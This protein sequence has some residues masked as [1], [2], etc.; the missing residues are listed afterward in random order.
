MADRRDWGGDGDEL[1][2]STHQL[3]ERLWESI[4]EIRTRLDKQPPVQP[5]VAAPPVEEEVVLVPLAPPPPPPGV[6]VLPVAPVPPV[7]PI[8]SAMQIQQAKIEQFRTLQQGNLSVLELSRTVEEAA[9]RAAI[10]ERT[11]HASR[12]EEAAGNKVFNRAKVLDQCWR[13]HSKVQPGCKAGGLENLSSTDLWCIRKNVT[14]TS[15]VILHERDHLLRRNSITAFHGRGCMRA[16]W[17]MQERRSLIATMGAGCTVQLKGELCG[18][19]AGDSGLLVHFS[20]CFQREEVLQSVENAKAVSCQAWAC[21][22]VVYMS[23]IGWSPQFLDLVEVERQ[24]DLS[25]VAA[26]LR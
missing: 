25:S 13:S 16:A 23:S 21:S 11:I 19:L 26:R 18:V 22:R 24:L 14:N 3:I 6:E 8:R 15:V 2:E 17:C 9:Q 10:L 12:A 20:A 5:A 1:E 4:M 7:V